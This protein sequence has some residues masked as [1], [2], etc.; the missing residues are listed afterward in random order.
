MN[1]YDITITAAG[2]NS[3]APSDGFID[4]KSSYEYMSIDGDAPDN[5]TNALAK[6]RA[7]R[8][9]KLMA[10]E[11]DGMA[12]FDVKSV[13]KTGGSADSAPSQIVIRVIFEEPDNVATADE[14]NPGQFLRGITAIKRTVARGLI[15]TESRN[16][17]V[18]DP[19]LVQGRQ[20]DGVA[21]TPRMR[22]PVIATQ[23]I[24]P[25]AASLAAAEAAITVTAIS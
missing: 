23:A 19:T 12:N 16:C 2:L 5:L 17:E 14:N 22:G 13:T 18:F 20:I 25:L 10:L 6:M 4:P 24:G 11:L 8:R 7:N 9:Y 15:A 3:T 1:T 21:S